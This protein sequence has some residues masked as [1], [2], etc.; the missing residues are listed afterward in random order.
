MTRIEDFP[1]T[2]LDM[3]LKTTSRGR[4]LPTWVTILRVT[5]GRRWWRRARGSLLNA[6]LKWI[7]RREGTANTPTRFLPLRDPTPPLL[8]PSKYKWL[9]VSFLNKSL[10]VKRRCPSSKSWK[11]KAVAPNIIS[12]LNPNRIFKLRNSRSEIPPKIIKKSSN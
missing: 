6:F 10:S 1:A 11:D 9:K 7:I 2:D 3:L 5:K 4:P 8:R 12:R